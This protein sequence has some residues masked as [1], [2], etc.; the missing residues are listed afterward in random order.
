MSDAADAQLRE[1]LRQVRRLEL[2]TERLV[3]SLAA[4][5]YRSRFRGQGMEFE[6]VREYQEGDDVRHI[7]WNVTARAGRAF[8]KTFREERDLTCM[9]L[10]DVSGSMRFGA[11]PG[12]SNRSKQAVAAEAAAIIGV[13]ALRNNDLIGLV[14]F[15]DHSQAHLRPRK[16]RRHAMRVI[17]TC[18][19]QQRASGA[20][21]VCD[22]IEEF[23][24]IADKRSVCFVIS[25][26]LE[27]EPRLP[28]VLARA[29]RRHDLIGL[30]IADPAEEDVPD[31][32]APLAMIDPETGVERSFAGGKQARA[33]YRGAWREQRSQVE[34]AFGNA[35][36]ELV[37]LSTA[38]ATFDAVRRFFA[39]RR[40]RIAV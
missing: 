6:E 12:F 31:G 30:R 18:L 34:R 38:E 16:G 29:A 39:R 4:G 1:L 13:T 17:R 5:Q 36:C 10:V 26:F 33:R 20:T 9:L 24:S 32:G 22:A 21:R 25:D 19:D 15:S 7:D 2:R 28:T 8:V 3:D 11:L 35:G 40:R 27:P 37:D 23:V 14:T